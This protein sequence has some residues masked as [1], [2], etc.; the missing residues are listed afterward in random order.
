[1]PLPVCR[2]L[3]GMLAQVGEP[4]EVAGRKACGFVR[5]RDETVFEDEQGASVVGTFVIVG[6]RTDD[7]FAIGETI[8]VR[9][10]SYTITSAMQGVGAGAHTKLF[11]REVE[12]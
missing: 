9:R 3:V 2:D 11:C 6:M 4:V 12:A 1:M 8:V 5:F 7:Q 10:K